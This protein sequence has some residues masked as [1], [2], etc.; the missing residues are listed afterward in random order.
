MQWEYACLVLD[1][2]QEPGPPLT[3]PT[4]VNTYTFESP[5]GKKGVGGNSAVEILNRLGEEGWEVLTVESTYFV[6]SMQR[7]YW[8]KRPRSTD[9]SR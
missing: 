8:L 9:T 5:N 6:N 1:T 2:T 7:L 3:K 4:W